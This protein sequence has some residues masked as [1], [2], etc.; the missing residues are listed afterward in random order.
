MSCSREPKVSVIIPTY[1]RAKFLSK[2]LE[3]ALGQT[4]D[5]F[6]IIIVD[7]G[8]TDETRA[9]LL[10]FK[11]KRIRILRTENQGVAKA[12]NL[13][14]RKSRGELIAF[15]DSDDYWLPNKLEKQLELFNDKVGLVY[16]SSFIE[17]DQGK[18][19]LSARFSGLVE[20]EFY[21]K[22]I[23][24][25]VVA[26]MSTAVVRKSLLVAING[27][28]E[29][30]PPPS[31]DYDLYWR[32]SKLTE[33]DYVNEPLSHIVTHNS[34]ISSNLNQYHLGSI[35]VLNKMMKDPGLSTWMNMRMGTKVYVMLIKSYL[36]VG[37]VVKTW[38]T[39]CSL[40]TFIINQDLGG[41]RVL[42]RYIQEQIEPN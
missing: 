8:S 6:E 32:I 22:P 28:D 29:L 9:L 11:D 21:R 15:L 10:T 35:Y 27:F 19:V 17:S 37:A 20:R 40:V 18:L 41:D 23:N 36:K 42:R 1:N 13:G 4:Y 5:N 25:I 2:A 3:S 26:G 38:Q 7:D 34:N 39:L 31:E 14:I 30:V 16:S 12:R 33:F 24:V